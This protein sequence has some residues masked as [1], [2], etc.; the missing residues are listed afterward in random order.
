MKELDRGPHQSQFQIYFKSILGTQTALCK[1]K[2]KETTMLW[3]LH[4]SSEEK[5]NLE[6]GTGFFL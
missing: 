6:I 4:H 1:D 2:Q 5:D 3:K